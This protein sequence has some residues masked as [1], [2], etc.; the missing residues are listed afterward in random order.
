MLFVFFLGVKSRSSRSWESGL[1]VCAVDFLWKARRTWWSHHSLS[2][3]R[4]FMLLP[5][6][7][8]TAQICQ[9]G[10]S[11]GDY[12]QVSDIRLI[13]G[14]R[15]WV[16]KQPTP[17]R[18]VLCKANGSMDSHTKRNQIWTKNKTKGQTISFSCLLHLHIVWWLETSRS[19]GGARKVK[20]NVPLFAERTSKRHQAENGT[21][22]T[23]SDRIIG[24]NAWLNQLTSTRTNSFHLEVLSWLKILIMFP[25]KYSLEPKL[26]LKMCRISPCWKLRGTSGHLSQD[27]K[28]SLDK[29]I[30]KY[31]CCENCISTD[32]VQ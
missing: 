21:V 25:D 27:L 13:V 26:L 6:Y 1:A 4:F 8:W 15:I 19:L 10:S 20:V 30:E 18:C 28:L 9:W 3:M 11:K 14:L 29:F 22:G 32:L 24:N 31:V 5:R 7:L 2:L 12:Q 23:P 16:L 17:T